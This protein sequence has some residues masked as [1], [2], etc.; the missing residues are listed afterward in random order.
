MKLVFTDT[1]ICILKIVIDDV[2]EDLQD[3]SE[4]MDFSDYYIS[5]PSCDKTCKKVLRKIEDELSGRTTTSCMGLGP[6]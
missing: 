4:H 2:H 5:H 6:L 1:N 3:L